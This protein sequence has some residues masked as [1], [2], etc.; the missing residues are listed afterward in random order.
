MLYKLGR[1]LTN[2]VQF[3]LEIE[4]FGRTVKNAAEEALLLGDF[5]VSRIGTGLLDGNSCVNVF[6]PSKRFPLAALFVGSMALD[7]VGR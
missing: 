2:V 4:G 6:D 3:L 5:R 7:Y 1:P